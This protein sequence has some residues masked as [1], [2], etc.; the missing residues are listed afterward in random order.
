MPLG[1]TRL[2][3]E[4]RDNTDGHHQCRSNACA[5]TPPESLEH[6]REPFAKVRILDRVKRKLMA[7]TRMVQ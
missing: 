3:N 1:S 2:E 6:L 7:L 4:G 5:T